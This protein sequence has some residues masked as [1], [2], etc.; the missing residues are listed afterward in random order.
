MRIHCPLHRVKKTK[1]NNTSY[2]FT[3]PEALTPEASLTPVQGEGRP[4]WR[5]D[6]E[7]GESLPQPLPAHP[8]PA[9]EGLTESALHRYRVRGAG[10]G[11]A[12]AAGRG[13]EE[14]PQPLLEAVRRGVWSGFL[15][16]GPHRSLSPYRAVE[17][18]L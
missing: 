15:R 5:T 6:N 3:R 8:A 4:S 14:L 17:K 16:W 11:G 7:R 13:A 10:P 9:Q 12:L 18:D 2:I 1:Q